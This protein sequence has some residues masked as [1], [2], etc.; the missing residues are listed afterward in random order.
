MP[1]V[2]DSLGA[3][4]IENNNKTLLEHI[5]IALSVRKLPLTIEKHTNAV[6]SDSPADGPEF[7]A[8]VFGSTDRWTVMV[9]NYSSLKTKYYIRTGWRSTWIDSG[10]KTVDFK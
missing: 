1:Y 4:V 9:Y 7:T 3:Y 2:N 10:W 6:L 5:A 8:I